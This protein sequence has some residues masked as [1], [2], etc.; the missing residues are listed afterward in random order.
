MID[1]NYKII[2]VANTLDESIN[3]FNVLKENA[4][5]K[6][7]K[8]F[9]LCPAFS[10][11]PS[12]MNEFAHV[13]E[14]GMITYYLEYD[15]I[16]LS[17]KNNALLFINSNSDNILTGMTY[18]DFYNSEV[19]VLSYHDYNLLPNKF[20]KKNKTLTIWLDNYNHKKL[21][22][23]EVIEVDCFATRLNAENDKYIKYMYF[24]GKSN[25]EI[26]D[27]IFEYIDEETTI[28]RRAE[29]LELYE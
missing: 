4:K 2:I 1:K 3:L 22:Y 14:C 19:M 11:I 27:I 18:E 28:N 21:N 12:L 17:L 16:K 13:D 7:D 10:N 15:T 20:F 29:L 6:F 8:E 25:E 5:E 26:A 24:L 23:N 9:K